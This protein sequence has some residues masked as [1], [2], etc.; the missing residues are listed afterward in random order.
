VKALGAALAV[1]VLISIAGILGVALAL[2]VLAGF[3]V[4]QLDELSAQ[5][6]NLERRGAPV[7]EA[8]PATVVIPPAPPPAVAPVQAPA[9]AAPVYW[10]PPRAD[11]DAEQTGE[12]WSGWKLPALNELEGLLAGRG[13][14]VVGGIALTLGMLFFLGLAFSRGWIGPEARVVIGLVAGGLI[15]AVGGWL[16]L[17]SRQ[18]VGHVL[19]AVGLA[20]VM[21]SLFAATQL[22]AFIPGELGVGAALA[23]AAVT[24][25][26][27]IRSN[28]QTIAG[29]GLV[30]VLAAPPVM[31]ASATLLTIAFLGVALAGTT[32]IALFRS[33]R[34]L[35]LVAFLLAGP[36]FASYV[37]G[38][39]ILAI[40]LPALGIFWLLHALAAGG[41]EFRLYRGG[42]SERSATL[43]VANAAFLV[44]AGF[45]LL[46][47]D[48]EPFRGVF[49]LAVTV[50]HLGLALPFLLRDER[51]P[52]GMLAFGTGIAALTLAAPVQ[53]GA[54]IV[55]MAWAAEA[56]AL[57]WIYAERRHGYSG[58]AA[59]VLGGLAA[60]HIF[61]IEYPLGLGPAFTSGIPFLNPNGATLGFVVAAAAVA[62]WLVSERAIRVAIA[63]TAGALLIAA[64]R[65]ELDGP[66][67]I[68]FLTVLAV[69]AM[70]T[71]KRLL[72]IPL[73]VPGADL[74]TNVAER[75]L[76][77]TAAL[78]VMHLA[79]TTLSEHLPP[80]AFLDG[81]RAYATLPFAP[82]VNEAS[83]VAA[84]LI[85][86]GLSVAFLVPDRTW[87]AS[88]VLVGAAV[89]AYLVPSQAGP[90]VSVAVW[91]LLGVVLFL[92]VAG[93]TPQLRYAPHVFIG[94][95]VLEALAVVAA[96]D[97]LVVR[98][99]AF[100]EAALF[101]GATLAVAA[102]SIAFAIRARL[103]PRDREGMASAG[104]AAAFGVYLVSIAT[105][106][107]FQV[108]LGG[109]IALEELQKQAQVALSVVWAVIG[110]GAMVFGL[111]RRWTP[112]RIFGLGLLGLVTL[113]VFIVDL[114]ALDVAYRVLSFVALG[115]LLLG[116][117]YLYSRFQ[118]ASAS[119][120]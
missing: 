103:E 6:R 55:P 64:A 83:L 79:L 8:P 93:W 2:A 115:V 90:A 104:L 37:L 57:T 65:F 92:Y 67:L 72:N 87:R 102:L 110:V 30:A 71:E 100:P 23:V 56:V 17:R 26:L 81:L 106:D 80:T 73:R 52:F 11:A 54:P 3:V 96:P 39:P 35:P 48:F 118:P 82:F 59:V 113:K 101:N 94:A 89:L 5:V 27:A 119:R 44:W 60:V 34:W 31:G 78:A 50:A 97:R 107:L 25:L 98:A 19:V 38:S 13:L 45:E 43:L 29:F 33:W 4:W 63:A 20:A 62:I 76:Y 84:I 49:L 120:G 105:V 12:W 9:P 47:A 21:L 18:I 66:A 69:G 109:P 86:G 46:A 58:L 91:S 85:A 88:G 117:A 74:T 40:A 51:Q 14:A 10:Q 15:F 112:A 75:A 68:A 77:G 7:P 61:A 70:L 41:E 114:A 32:A 111:A 108:R 16:L 24:A 22:Y 1:I 42:L 36:Q 116:A 53:L 28:S 95:A 99:T